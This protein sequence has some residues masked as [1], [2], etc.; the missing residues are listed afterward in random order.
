MFIIA[1]TDGAYCWCE[2]VTPTC[3]LY[4]SFAQEALKYRARSL[5]VNKT[6]MRV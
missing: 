1:E 3:G 6:D 2:F 4:Y 5:L